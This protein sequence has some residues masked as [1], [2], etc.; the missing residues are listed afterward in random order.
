MIAA[1]AAPDATTR[2]RRSREV[3]WPGLVRWMAFT[4]LMTMGRVDR[5]HRRGVN[6]ATTPPR[7]SPTRPRP[8]RLV[9]EV[10]R[11]SRRDRR[12][13]SVSAPVRGFVAWESTKP[14]LRASAGASS[15]VLSPVSRRKQRSASVS[16]PVRGFCRVGVDRSAGRGAIGRHSAGFVACESTP[17]PVVPSRGA[18]SRVLSP[19]SRRNRHFGHPS[20]SAYG[21]CRLSVDENSGQPP[22]RGQLTGLVAYQ[23]TDRPAGRPC[24]ASSRVLS[25]GSR[26]GRPAYNRPRCLT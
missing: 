3:A 7:E 6:F 20:A 25:P 22:F 17:P 10:S 15:R 18:S 21:S 8:R 24:G 23:S 14:P 2:R 16:A 26:R 4:P 11:T 13:G 12:R 5:F 9:L 1:T 19:D